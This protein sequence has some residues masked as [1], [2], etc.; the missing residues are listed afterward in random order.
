MT[1]V[2]NRGSGQIP[3]NNLEEAAS[4]YQACI[5]AGDLYVALEQHDE[6]PSEP[7]VLRGWTVRVLAEY[8]GAQD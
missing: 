6:L 8:Q 5:D 4:M 7:G 1:Y 2:V 3:Y